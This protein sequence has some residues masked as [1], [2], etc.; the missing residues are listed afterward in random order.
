LIKYLKAVQEMNYYS[1]R[2]PQV[3]LLDFLI[4]E[5]R[6]LDYQATN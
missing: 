4:S 3:N 2:I 6:Y 1:D 5:A